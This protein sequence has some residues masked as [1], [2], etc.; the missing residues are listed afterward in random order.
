MTHTQR[1]PSPSTQ[2]N[3]F[4]P[5]KVKRWKEKHPVIKIKNFTELI[6]WVSP[7]SL[8]FPPS[9]LYVLLSQKKNKKKKIGEGRR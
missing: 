7:P 9:I 8:N 5:L 1:F 2:K 4:P 3:P 6:T